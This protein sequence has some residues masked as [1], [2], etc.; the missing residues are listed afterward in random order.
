M[1]ISYPLKDTDGKEFDSLDKIMRL[2][3]A[4]A[5]GTWLLGGNQYRRKKDHRYI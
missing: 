1:K 4:E 5:N 3:D 2:I